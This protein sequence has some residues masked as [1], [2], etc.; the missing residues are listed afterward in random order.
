MVYQFMKSGGGCLQ[1][2]ICPPPPHRVG[3][4]W[5][6]VRHEEMVFL[7]AAFPG[8]HADNCLYRLCG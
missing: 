8:S 5:N 1:N 7:G 3:R 4:P 2:I 6:H